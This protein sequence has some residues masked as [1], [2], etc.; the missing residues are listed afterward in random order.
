MTK[1]QGSLK[2]KTAWIASTI[3]KK[4]KKKWFRGNNGWAP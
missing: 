3:S 1:P 2:K 4:S